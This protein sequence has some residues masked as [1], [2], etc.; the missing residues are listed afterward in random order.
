MGEQEPLSRLLP[1]RPRRPHPRPTYQLDGT[2]E[3]GGHG[4]G[5]GQPTEIRSPPDVEW[6]LQVEDGVRHLGGGAG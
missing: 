6:L 4:G 5:P 2:I 1:S 3:A